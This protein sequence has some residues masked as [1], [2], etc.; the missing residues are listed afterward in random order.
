MPRG[1]QSASHIVKE[2]AYSLKVPHANHLLPSATQGV[3]KD[4]CSD[5]KHHPVTKGGSLAKEEPKALSRV[6][7]LNNVV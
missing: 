1:S 5:R 6:Q 3:V 7:V 4:L 2:P